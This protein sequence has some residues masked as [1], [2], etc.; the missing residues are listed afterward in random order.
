MLQ[1]KQIVDLQ[2]RRSCKSVA[3]AAN[4]R[5]AC[6]ASLYKTVGF[7]RSR[8]PFG[9]QKLRFC[10]PSICL[11]TNPFLLLSKRKRFAGVAQPTALQTRR[12]CTQIFDL[13]SK[14]VQGY[15]F[16]SKR[17]AK[18]VK[19]RSPELAASS[20]DTRFFHNKAATNCSLVGPSEQLL[21]VA[22]GGSTALSHTR[23]VSA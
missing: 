21:C 10:N 6:T 5:F 16:V 12:V 2:H 9:T 7:V 15:G 14:A 23:R 11:L 13:Q 3:F 22:V 17:T 4:L 19:R 1:R 18:T 8:T 20:P